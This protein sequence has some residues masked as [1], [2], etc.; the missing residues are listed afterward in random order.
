MSLQIS[1]LDFF[2]YE[3]IYAL[4]LFVPSCLD[5]FDN[6]KKFLARFES[7]EPIKKYLNSNR[8]VKMPLSAPMAHFGGKVLP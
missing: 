6:L 2:L 5:K 8:Y 7:L 3:A 4:T 1:Y